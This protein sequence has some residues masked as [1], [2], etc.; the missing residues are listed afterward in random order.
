[1]GE[2]SKRNLKT[3]MKSVAITL[4]F[5]ILLQLCTPIAIGVQLENNVQKLGKIASEQAN[6]KNIQ[7]KKETKEISE[8]EP[9]II[10]EIV[11]K[12]KLN[13]KHFLQSDGTIIAA[14]Y[15]RDV[16]YEEDGKLI[17]I[18]N[19][20]ETINESDKNIANE[21]VTENNDE[22]STNEEIYQNKN[23]TVKVKF[24][25]KSNKNNLVKL[26]IKN[27][28]IKWSILNSKKVNA[29]KVE[30]NKPEDNKLN[31]NKISSGT[32]KYEEILDNIDIQYNV[33]S[34]S[35]KEDIIL[36][37]KLAINQEISFEFQTDNL[38]MEKT[39][40]NRI[41][42]SE[43]NQESVLF[44]LEAPYMYD[45]KNEICNDIEVEL[46]KDKD[47]KYKMTLKPNK[48]WLESKEREYPI[49]IDPTVQTSLDYNHIN[50]TYIFDGDT[51]YP[52]RHE[53]HIL[54]VGS[55]NSISPYK[56]PVR[57]L[58][59]FNLPNLNSGDQV[60]KAMLDICSYPDT[61]EWIP[62]TEEIQIN[63][64]KMTA[65]WNVKTANWNE[66][67]DK[68]EPYIKDY[69]K[70]KYDS[71]NQIK[72][73]YFDITSIVKDWYVTGNNYGVVLKDHTET[74]NSSHS[75]AYFYSSDVSSS[76]INARPMIQM[77][78][79]NQTGIEDYQTYHT[80]TVGRAGTV[81]TN[82]Y[83][84][85]LVLTHQD[86][87]T[88][89]NLLP[90]TVSHIYN[91]NN[92]DIDIGYGKGFR[93]NL[94]QTIKIVTIDN[95]EYAKYI[96]E[97]GTEHYFK[98]EGNEYK[99][100]DGLGLTLTLDSNNINFIMKDKEKNILLFE[101]RI[102]SFGENW[103]LRELKDAFGNKIEIQ[104]NPNAWQDFRINKVVDAAGDELTFTYDDTLRL[105]KIT[106][107]AG[108]VTTFEYNSNYTVKQIKD[109]DGEISKYEYNQAYLLTSVKNIDNSHVDY[110]YYNEKSNRVKSIKE[111]S[112]Q[113]ELGKSINISYGYN[114]TRFTDNK[115]YT[116]TYT[117]NNFGQTVSI[118]DLGKDAS[119]ID[120]AYGKMYK[121]GEKNNDK[122]K[123]TLEGNLISI[124]NKENN[125]I[126]NG[127]FSNGLNYWGGVHTDSNDKVVNGKLTIWRK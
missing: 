20:L 84:G 64:Q 109:P 108:K 71:N 123:L 67:H 120:N 99:D 24:F 77:V 59:K 44:L 43:E 125:L 74:Y 127:N 31:I 111:Y 16:H 8:T 41:V 68:V 21:E 60:I 12:R 70:Y 106:D 63:V 122:N 65:D 26:K 58:I 17:D 46:I 29:K 34:N 28:N 66:L 5:I 72:F 90:A 9:E 81:Y 19:T 93:T 115:G 23:N 89:G 119:N 4:I 118:S 52:N 11:E 38:K 98:K 40:D 86:V 97:D 124:S 126:K 117:F 112:T 18:D 32:V 76:Y 61:N 73:Y 87:S 83:N 114:I 88:K 47:N 102:N 50:D 55:N 53:A 22:I 121:Y 7:N 42:F 94:S 33:I 95:V 116:N 45:A 6:D 85:N 25:K 48:E 75:D 105:T 2:S 79:R 113:N 91:T 13:E 36:K 110:E 3:I 39:E 107:K 100:E 27:H 35:I 57:S 10:G 78:Y 96:D 104:L 101:K 51:G 14:V 49:T 62:P 69:V 37:N 92:K 80:Q 15:P 103:H 1:M 82:D 54:R 30:D 56:A